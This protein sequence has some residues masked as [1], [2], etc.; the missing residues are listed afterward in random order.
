MLRRRRHRLVRYLFHCPCLPPCYYTGSG[1]A[2]IRKYLQRPK[3]LTDYKPQHLSQETISITHTKSKKLRQIP[4]HPELAEA[5]KAL[6]HRSAYVFCDSSGEKLSANGMARKAFEKLKADLVL[7]D[8]TFHGL[9]H[10]FASELVGKG[11]DL[12]TVQEYLGHSSLRMVQRYSHVS[13][14]IWRSTIQLLGRD[15]SDGSL[16]R[17]ADYRMRPI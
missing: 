7:T 1:T 12:R 14:G 5:L 2:L 8:L 6:P 11:A 17:Q 16:L 15:L 9:R 10:N 3:C 4:I 13:K